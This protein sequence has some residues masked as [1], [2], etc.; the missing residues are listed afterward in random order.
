[1]YGGS[2]VEVCA[3]THRQGRKESRGDEAEQKWPG[4]E[5]ENVARDEPYGTYPER[6]PLYFLDFMI[7]FSF[8]KTTRSNIAPTFYVLKAYSPFNKLLNLVRCPPSRHSRSQ[9]SPGP[10]PL[11]RG[12]P[13]QK[14]C[15]HSH[16]R[17]PEI[18][19]I[20]VFLCIDIDFISINNKNAKRTKKISREEAKKRS[21]SFDRV[22]GEKG[23]RANK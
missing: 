7:T 20:L 21:Y 14:G 15:R 10:L 2:C 5:L 3:Y 17:F 11:K 4:R 19:H 18:D 12:D 1:M 13:A 6:L 22:L 8:P 9:P 23:T 16:I